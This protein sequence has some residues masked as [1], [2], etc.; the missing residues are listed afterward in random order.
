MSTD[1]TSLRLIRGGRDE[2]RLGTLRVAVAPAESAP[3]PVEAE[4]VEEDT[5]QVLGAGP[6]VDLPTEHPVQ[7][8]TEVLSAQP[9]PPG[10]VVVREGI[11]LR[12]MAVVHDLNQEPSCRPEWV[13]AALGE[14]LRI[15][16]E[17]TIRTLSLPLMGVRHGRLP[18]AGFVHLLVVAVR[19]QPRHLQKLWLIVPEEQWDEVR[20]LLAEA[21]K[22][23]VTPAT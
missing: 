23:D 3:F 14:G 17:R 2:L 13:A 7:I 19:E 15:A 10:S 6:D 18:A 11:P 12:L 21:A 20:G 16:E 9:L 1:K 8:L 5:W 4:I 22:S